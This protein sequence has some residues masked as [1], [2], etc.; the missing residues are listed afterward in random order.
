MLRIFKD[1]FLVLKL[2]EL[3]RSFSLAG[4]FRDVVNRA[5]F[6]FA[7]LRE[8][9]FGGFALSHRARHPEHDPAAGFH[10]LL[11]HFAAAQICFPTSGEPG[12]IVDGW[13]LVFGQVR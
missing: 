2:H 12:E 3:E 11:V 4:R 7:D 1:S 13:V 10:P 6:V 8:L 9:E 5:V